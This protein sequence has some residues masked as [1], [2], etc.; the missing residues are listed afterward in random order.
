MPQEEGWSDR[1]G[2][3]YE[4]FTIWEGLNIIRAIRTRGLVTD[5]PV[6]ST[7]GRVNRYVRGSRLLTCLPITTD[8][9]A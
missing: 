9:G 4:S 6:L 2:E 3:E 5:A 7:V 1:Y 8:R